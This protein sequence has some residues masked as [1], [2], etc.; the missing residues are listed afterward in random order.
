MSAEY[1]H[2]RLITIISYFIII[3]GRFLERTSE[4]LM[5][6]NS[7]ENIN[8]EQCLKKTIEITSRNYS[9]GFID[10]FYDIAQK[11]CQSM[12]TELSDTNVQILSNIITAQTTDDIIQSIF[13][14]WQKQ[15]WAFLSLVIAF[16]FIFLLPIS[17]FFFFCSRYCYYGSAKRKNTNSFEMLPCGYLALL[18]GM[19]AI[20]I[21]S[22]TL[23]IES[24]DHTFNN[25]K[26]IN[27]FVQNITEDVINVTEIIFDH[28]KCEMDMKLPKLFNKMKRLVR[29][30]P[31]NAFN[32]YKESDG[33]IN[34]QLAIN[35]L[36]NISWTLNITAKYLE[37]IV[38]DIRSLPLPLQKKLSNLTMLISDII[39]HGYQITGHYNNVQQMNNTWNSL[40][41]LL[42]NSNEMKDIL[43][44]TDTLIDDA[45]KE[46]I[47]MVAIIYNGSVNIIKFIQKS[48]Q[49]VDNI[50]KQY[51]ESREFDQLANVLYAVIAISALC[52]I[53]PTIIVVF[54]GIT[55]LYANSKSSSKCSKVF[56][57]SGRYCGLFALAGAFFTGWIIMLVASLSFICGYSIEALSNPLFRDS[58]MRFFTISPLF[59]F[60][61]Q[62]PI[63]KK[64]FTTDIGNII[65]YCKEN[66]TILS[67]L[68]FER[69]INIDAIIKK[70]DIEEKGEKAIDALKNVNLKQY[71]PEQVFN[72]FTEDFEQLENMNTELHN[73]I[74]SDDI[75]ALNESLRDNLSY[76]N[77]N[78]SN[79]IEVMNYTV[80]ITQQLIEQYLYS[81]EIINDSAQ[82]IEKECSNIVANIKECIYNSTEYF[83]KNSYICRP[84]YDIWEN[85]GLAVSQKLSR[86]VQGVWMSTSVLSLSYVPVIIL[87]TLIIRYLARTNRKYDFKENSSENA[88]A[89]STTTDA[90][91]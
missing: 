80:I 65:K 10:T 29:R 86:P 74:I 11:I 3:H 13:L 59:Q 44:S 50:H 5:S 75:T 25:T 67:A 34:M 55:K 23:S 87:T 69:L 38:C 36:K 58:E 26:N 32:H 1:F 78:I 68:E 85:T 79:L 84:F 9:F 61:I 66:E 27:K 83:R 54:S 19:Q 48:N 82:I 28:V 91:Q 15:F 46:A 77:K 60:T 73:F 45:G 4:A 33:Y 49:K 18:I 76:M 51:I 43:E 37:K 63:D 7:L 12:Q 53:T 2:L 88:I 24:I 40:D 30:L 56:F 42:F 41:D 62:N 90:Y 89:M 72:E 52:V 16:A 70:I 31:S 64:N 17:G 81:N 35:N 21:G 47:K 22:L 14:V 39:S 57:N 8:P 71:F 6:G 20:M